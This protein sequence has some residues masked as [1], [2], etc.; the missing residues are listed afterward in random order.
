MISVN[1]QSLIFSLKVQGHQTSTKMSPLDMTA[2]G[3]VT[4]TSH[5]LPKHVNSDLS[6]STEYDLKEH[7][8]YIHTYYFD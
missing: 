7:L 1:S 3:L 4:E 6:S 8:P 2:G 5:T